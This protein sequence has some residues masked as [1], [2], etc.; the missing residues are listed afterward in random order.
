MDYLFESSTANPSVRT[1]RPGLSKT[2]GW[3]DAWVP[4]LDTVLK[5]QGLKEVVRH[6]VPVAP[7]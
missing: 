5:E 6:Y 3:N 4:K 1:H 2:V 7:Q